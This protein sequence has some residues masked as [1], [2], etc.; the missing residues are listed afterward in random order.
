MAAVANNKLG[1]KNKKN[2]NVKKVL[3]VKV[4]SYADAHIRST[5]NN[6]II[7]I[8]TK[9]GDT[10][11]WASSG[12]MGFKGAKKSTPY[13]AKCAAESCCEKALALGVRKVDIKVN[14]PGMGRE[15]AIRAIESAGISVNSIIDNTKIPYNGCRP[16]KR[17]RP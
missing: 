2:S 17:R 1:S 12:M 3:K 14:G 7:S 16:A 9:S 13:A 11:S 4:D 6:V 15:S 10:I 5:F 8:A